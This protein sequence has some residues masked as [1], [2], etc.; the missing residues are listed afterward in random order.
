MIKKLGVKRELIL[1]LSFTIFLT[2]C[3][4]PIEFEYIGDYPELY[5]VAINSILG[6][7]GYGVA[8]MTQP[9]II[10]LEEDDYGRILFSYSE[11]AAAGNTGVSPFNRVIIQKTDGDYAYFYPHYNF[12]SNSS[13]R[14]TDEEIETLKEANSWNQEMSDSSEFL[15]VRIVRQQDEGPIT[16]EQLIE[17]H[18]LILPDSTA[19]NHQIIGNTTF[20][21]T[22]DVGRS[23]YLRRGTIGQNSIAILFQPD[24]SFDIETGTLEIINPNNYQT[25][26]RLFMEANGWDEP[27]DD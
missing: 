10:V 12:I 27:W 5:S 15:R 11:S 25:E 26:L 19:N 22:D 23:I 8:H 3:L 17:T 13:G 14:F 18:H 20:L 9:N 21:R 7:R 16:D 2:A 6:A 4:P 1:V 24:H